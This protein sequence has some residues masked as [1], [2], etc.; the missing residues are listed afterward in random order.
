MS[1]LPR[2]DTPHADRPRAGF[3][4]RP[5][6]S[7]LM[8]AA[9]VLGFVSA[10]FAQGGFE[11]L[12]IADVLVTFEGSDT[13]LSLAEQFRLAARDAVGSTYSTVRIRDAVE[14]LYGTRRVA[15]IEVEATP[16]EPN[17]VTLRFV[18]KRKTQAQRVSVQVVNGAEE[19]GVT[20]QELLFRLT[21]L[22][23]GSIVDEQILQDNTNLI[24][25]YLRERGYFNAEVTYSQQPLGTAN[26]VAVVFRVILNARAQVRTFTID[27]QGIDNRI[28]DDKLKLQPGSAFSQE[29]LRA[30]EEKIREILRGEGFLAPT[31]SEARPVLDPE[32]NKIDIT[33]TGTKGPVVE[34]EVDSERNR[35]GSG[36]QNRLLPIRRDGTLD[37]SAIIEGERRLENHY[38]ELGYFF[39]NV[40]SV[41]SVEPPLQDPGSGTPA[42]ETEFLC[43]VL[44]NSDLMDRKVKVTY[45]VDLSR[46]LKLTEIRLTGTDQFTIDDIRS[47]LGSQEANVLGIIPLFG[48]GRGYTSETL[49]DRDAATIQSLLSGLGYRDSTVRV[50]QGVSLDGESLVITF[51]VDQGPP[52]VISSVRVVGNKDLTEAVLLQQLPPLVGKN[53]SRARMRNGQQ[54]LTE[55]LAQAGYF[56]ATVDPSVD[57]GTVDAATGE[58]L[59]GITYE[60][61]HRSNPLSGGLLT[62]PGERTTLPGEGK[63]VYVGRVMITG[64][65]DTKASAIIRALS[66]RPNTLL[67][68]GDIYASEQALYSTDVFSRVEVKEQPAG[69]TPDGR[70]TDLIV[71]VEEQAP[72]I[73]SY[74]GGFAT[75]LGASGFVD[76][77]HMNLFG[78]LWQG[79][80]RVRVS[81]RQQLAQI[82]FLNP[83]FLRDGENR[84]APLT[85][86]AQYLRDS[87]VTRFFRSAFD[88]GTFGIVQRLDENGNPIDE[89]GRDVG[90]PTLNRLTFTAET[91]R[92]LSRKDRSI[93]FVRY[94]FEDVRLYNIQSLLI[95]DLLEPDDNIR[96]SGFG[97]TFVRDTRENCSIRYTVLDIIERGDPGDPCR[98][99]ASDPTGGSYFTAE[100]NT[101]LPAL[102]A[103]IGFNKFQASYNVYYSP[104]ILRKTT[105]A[106]RAI[107]GLAHVFSSRDRFRNVDIPEL[108]GILPIS[109]RFFAG[110]A[111]TLRG[112]EFESAGPR[113]VIVPTGTFRNSNGE[114]VFLDPFTVPFGGNAL[115]V[116]NLEAR[117]PLAGSLR[118]VAFYDGGNVFRRIGDIFNP[119]DVPPDD[120]FRQNLRA[121]WSNTVGVGLRVKTPIGGEFGIDYGYLLNPP[122]FLIPQMNGPNANLRLRQGQFHFRFSQAF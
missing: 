58:R 6:L 31:L 64:N 29:D 98:Y 40:T 53:F 112:F 49:L 32:T 33:M 109:E 30:D 91:N 93:L 47:V 100:F 84:F 48:Y 43:S 103:N 38:Q 21:L 77:R 97:A 10:S 96:I 20:E 63:K 90:D 16:V 39:A 86:T 106:A 119:P 85:F 83:R 78:N 34:V 110:G 52:T 81:Q 73:L 24:L 108:E 1:F 114:Q 57:A 23:P 89:F 35:P 104:G 27:I 37:Y 117:F 82:D 46:R 70:L 41:C 99:S 113:V 9:A 107:V 74:G 105:F 2:S 76:I 25:E 7:A 54:R 111:N 88:R 42:N 116:V 44:S 92:T 36:T 26:E 66:V 122:S 45:R 17:S 69:D 3:P 95:K 75:D 11:G 51:V 94:R 72:R 5:F 118:A 18:I 8:A 68:A 55:F 4:R 28:F 101:S 120:V 67:R 56:D 22:D 19:T 62:A 80:A 59:L 65:E 79:G 60:I 121:I 115:A 15:S 61:R 12:R 71:N 13:N 87:T 102:G 50:N 14:Q